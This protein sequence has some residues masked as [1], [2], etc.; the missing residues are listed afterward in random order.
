LPFNE[1]E[2]CW[3]AWYE[4]YTAGRMVARLG[5]GEFFTYLLNTE[6]G[7]QE[8]INGTPKVAHREVVG[9]YINRN[10]Q[11]KR[12][13]MPSGWSTTVIIPELARAAYLTVLT[14]SIHDIV[15]ISAQLEAFKAV[16]GG[17]IAG[18]PLVLRRRP[19]KISTPKT[20]R[21]AGEN[22]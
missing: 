3:D 5:P 2:R 19:R 18:I 15:N 21:D 16:N 14:T 10:T 7:E 13:S 4:A 1:I 20:G 9:T 11:K 22:V 17:R 12:S 8:V 6:T